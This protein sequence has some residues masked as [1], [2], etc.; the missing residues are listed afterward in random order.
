MKR[1]TRLFR[2]LQWKLTFSY[3]LITVCALLLVEIIVALLLLQI[4]GSTGTQLFPTLMREKSQQASTYF[5]HNTLDREALTAWLNMQNAILDAFV[6]FKT[7][8]MAIVDA[9]GNVIA[10]KGKDAPAPNRSMRSY[11]TTVDADHL[12]QAL[13]EKDG[14]QVFTSAKPGS[15]QM[16]IVPIRGTET[17][18]EGAIVVYT[19]NILD[20]QVLLPSLLPSILIGLMVFTVCAGLAGTLFGFLTARGF[21]R[22]FKQLSNAADNWSRGNFN[23]FALDTSG[24][25]LGQLTRQ[26]NRMAEQLQNLLQTRQKLASLEERNRLARDLH[27]SVKQEIFAVSMQ[28]SAAKA[29]LKQDVDAAQVRMTEAERLVREAQQELTSLIRELRPV[30]LEGKGLATALQELVRDWSRQSGIAVDVEIGTVAN[31]TLSE[32]EALYRV[33]QEA[34][35]NVE[36]HSKASAVQLCLT[37]E[38]STTLLRLSDNGQGFDVSS[39]YGRGVG[40]LSMRERMKALHGDVMIESASGKGTVVQA[41]CKQVAAQVASL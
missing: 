11:L 38:N 2:R 12:R 15:Y 20:P 33:A 13:A 6:D 21:T 1:F 40:L 10:S 9:Q 4:S 3:T 7:G 22:R 29:L 35:A 28:I 31:L 36:R 32:E 34:L 26:L 37:S 30:A 18:V 16:L 27:D 23:A 39:A 17:Q 24:D 14:L 25:E 19:V 8:Y 41:L 5:L